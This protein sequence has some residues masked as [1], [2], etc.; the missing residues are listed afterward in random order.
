MQATRIASTVQRDRVDG[1]P[2]IEGAHAD[3]RIVNRAGASKLLTDEIE[4]LV[5]ADRRK[6]EFLAILSHELRSP[7]AAIQNAI[8]VLRSS[9]VIEVSVQN[10]MH[11]LIERQA[12][13]ISLLATGLLD[14]GRITRGQLLLQLERIDLVTV[15]DN[16]IETVEPDFTRRAQVFAATRPR[17][18]IWVL[19]DASRLEQVF[20]NLLAN[21]SK[22]TDEGGQISLSL[23]A[24]DGYAVVRIKDSGIGIAAHTLPDIFDLFMQVDVTSARSRSGV[25]VGLALVRK[26]VEMHDGSVIA[27]SA[28]LGQGSEFVVRL[29][30]H[31]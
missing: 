12:R 11:E 29:R 16:A 24:Q 31:G 5:L 10:G 4:K 23:Q 28:G 25:G 19:A 13:Q 2:P 3:I 7:L 27:L 14:V 26:I 18:S 20:V 6:D 1:R 22:Y 21:A 8:A 30:A 9:R 15:L 17:V